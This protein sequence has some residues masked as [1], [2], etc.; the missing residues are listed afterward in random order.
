MLD[1]LDVAAELDSNEMAFALAWLRQRSPI[2]LL[3]PGTSSAAHLR[4]N[5]AS[6][7]LGLPPEAIEKLEGIT[8]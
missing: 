5:I 8:E 6:A 7:R 3:I 1:V 4:K 2:I